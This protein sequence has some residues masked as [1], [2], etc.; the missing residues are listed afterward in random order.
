[1]CV[2]A[3]LLCR[4]PPSR[5]AIRWRISAR[6]PPP[7]P[8]YAAR[9]IST[10]TWEMSH[11]QLRLRMRFAAGM[12][13]LAEAPRYAQVGRTVEPLRSCRGVPTIIWIGIG[14]V[15]DLRGVRYWS[16]NDGRWRTLIA[17]AHAIDGVTTKRAG[18]ISRPAEIKSGPRALCYAQDD[19]PLASESHLRMQLS[20]SETG[21]D[22][23]T[24]EKT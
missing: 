8:P 23:R 2:L 20:A 17:D 21:P 10:V 18:R 5:W 6:T 24:I 4:G 9:S 7:V 19:S 12:R 13:R 14:A 15:S 22:G 3:F 1:M 16:V 11:A